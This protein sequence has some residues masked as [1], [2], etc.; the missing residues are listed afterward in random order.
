[1]CHNANRFAMITGQPINVRQMAS[2][3]VDR[4]SPNHSYAGATTAR[5]HAPAD[6]NVPRQAELT[7]LRQ[8]ETEGVDR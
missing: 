6:Q 3:R 7:G 1:M 4:L 2:A 8:R 5:P